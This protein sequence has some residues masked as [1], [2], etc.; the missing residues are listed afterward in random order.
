[1]FVNNCLK[2]IDKLKTANFIISNMFISEI[3]QPE[4]KAST[5]NKAK[6]PMYI[7]DYEREVILQ[8]EG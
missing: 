2:V 1:M 4:G 3:E 7:K 8:K 5:S 6:K